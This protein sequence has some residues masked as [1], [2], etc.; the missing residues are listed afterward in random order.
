VHVDMRVTELAEAERV[1]AAMA[2]LVAVHPDVR[3]EV[4]GGLNRP[5]MEESA[6]A[7]LYAL[8]QQVAAGIGV[9]VPVGVAVGGGS[10]GN[11][12]A[13]IGVPTLDGLGVTGG[14][15]HA[16][17]EHAETATMVERTLLLSAL[18]AAVRAR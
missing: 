8:A 16:V 12:T 5:P 4:V 13:A 11:L 10:D 2:A 14:G 17:T 15:A 18:I 6:A 1:E 3:L 7:D 9:P